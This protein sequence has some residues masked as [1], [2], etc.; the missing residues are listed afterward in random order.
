MELTVTTKGRVTIPAE[1]RKRF[2]IAPGQKVIF[3]ATK[4][5]ILVKPTDATARD[6]TKEP[7]W[8][9]SLRRSIAQAE[10]GEGRFYASTEEFF[11]ALERI[12][13][14]KPRPA[15]RKTKTK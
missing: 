4:S 7:A 9:R 12:P 13:Y 14:R 10:R 6:L 15:A 8:Q 1:L 2:G 3:A 5:G 11:A